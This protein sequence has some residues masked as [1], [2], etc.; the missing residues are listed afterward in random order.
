MKNIVEAFKNLYKGANVVKTHSLM[1][2][3]AFLSAFLVSLTN[4]IDA[5]EIKAYLIPLAIIA[6]IFIVLSVIST[7]FVAGFYV[8]FVNKRFT[9]SVGVPDITWDCF[10][11]GLKYIPITIVWFVY[12]S[13]P[14]LM[15]LAI[16][17]ISDF[18]IINSLKDD[19]I[20]ALVIISTL[21]LLGLFF[22]F[23]F[24]LA[25]FILQIG[26][27][28][29]ENFKYSKEIFNPLTPFRYMR[30]AFKE[31]IIIELKYLVVNMIVQF[32]SQLVMFVI[33]VIALI[34]LMLYVFI[35]N[36]PESPKSSLG[37]ALFMTVFSSLGV[38]FCYYSIW[39][40]SFAYSD[41]LLKVYKDKVMEKNIN[42]DN[43]NDNKL[44]NNQE[45]DEQ[46]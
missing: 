12:I 21:L 13:I 17:I 29:S 45:A 23:L 35:A 25:P 41:N 36:A 8:K 3:F 20:I 32:A 40:A 11:K 44:L 26:F 5:K 6:L 33:I 7:V 15:Y 4:F 19:L 34:F 14:F 42:V 28:F 1:A 46:E 22:V 31:S 10:L 38:A 39:I 18:L 43:C 24:L 9:D 16:I 2:L 37:V 27:K 30:K